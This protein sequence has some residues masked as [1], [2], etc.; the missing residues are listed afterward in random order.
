M[1]GGP[2]LAQADRREAQRA[3]ED[4]GAIPAELSDTLRIGGDEVRF[5]DF[6]LGDEE[7]IVDVLRAGFG[8]F[9]ASDKPVDEC[10]YITWFAE[11]HDSHFGRV[12]V[13]EVDSRIVSVTAQIR[14]PVKVGRRLLYGTAGGI[15]TTTHPD[16]QGRGFNRGLHA[17]R[18]A[19]VDQPTTAT[20][21]RSRMA[22]RA[23]RG[24]LTS[25]PG[26]GVHL[27]VLRPWRA[28]TG[29]SGA[30][31]RKALGYSGLAAWGALRAA[32]P[33]RAA[34]LAVRTLPAF[35]ER[36]ELFIEEAGAAWD[37]I[38]VRSVEY[39]NWRFGDPRA[40][41]FTVRAVELDDKLLGYA[42]LHRIGVRGH[43]VD[44]LA[45][46]NRLDV[47]RTLVDDATERLGRAGAAAVECWMLRRHPY[48]GVLRQSGFV[49]LPR[50]SSETDGEIS[51]FGLGMA[52][53]ERRLLISREARIHLVRADFD[54][55]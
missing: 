42:V 43:I 54:G 14:R 15:A 33:H 48:A 53:E 45:L 6:R 31:T 10:D 41:L 12:I 39:L 29:G 22:P 27:K 32:L 24:L 8:S 19:T 20:V 23:G 25:S 7:Q 16:F 26:M 49:P 5:R 34:E 21:E 17:W 38:P 47:V 52:P 44:V 28:A 13:A 4:G 9:Y 46:P 37:F 35:D 1:L 51:I 18:R 36:F 55:I 11:P 30:R 40:G 3:G 2:Q 50:A